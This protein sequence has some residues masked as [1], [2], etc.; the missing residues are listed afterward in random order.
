MRRSRARGSR[1][2]NPQL[3][4]R[5]AARLLREGDLDEVGPR[6]S[7]PSGRSSSAD[8]RWSRVRR[9]RRT[10]LPAR[11]VPG[12]VGRPGWSYAAPDGT[13]GNRYDDP[14][15]TASS[16]RRRD[17]S[18][19]SSKRSLNSGLISRCSRSSIGLKATTGRRRRCRAP[20]STSA[21]SAKRR[22]RDGSSMSAIRLRSPP[23][24]WRSRQ[25]AIRHGLDEIDAA[26]I[27]LRAPRA[28]TQQVSRFVYEQRD[29]EGASAGLRYRS[30]LGDDIINWAL[31]GPAPDV[32]AHSSRRAPRR[33]K[34]TTRI[35]KQP[36]ACSA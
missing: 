28:F 23:S 30:R 7:A 25:V 14:Q 2:Q 35:W 34:R 31:F 20:G 32:G 26:T 6:L 22:S 21:C 4:D 33:S 13:F 12:S 3:G 29:D 18:A 1:G 24:G 15:A 8:E 17:A 36:V 16:T 19:P 10:A 9:A 11:Q 27:R 5:S